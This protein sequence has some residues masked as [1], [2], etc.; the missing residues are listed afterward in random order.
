M[1]AEIDIGLP[2]VK[3]ETNKLDINEFI[4]QII[5]LEAESYPKLH[6]ASDTY[7]FESKHIKENPFAKLASLK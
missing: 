4:A 6:S 1:I 7:F 2:N 3:C 5:G